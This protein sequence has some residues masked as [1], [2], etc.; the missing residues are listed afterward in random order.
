MILRSKTWKNGRLVLRI[1]IQTLLFVASLD[2]SAKEP[3]FI[4]PWFMRK[5]K[6]RRIYEMHI[7]ISKGRERER[8]REK[9]WGGK[10]DI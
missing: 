2:D 5:F 1:S 4:F 9:E 8:E 6:N 10:R 7:S 3:Q